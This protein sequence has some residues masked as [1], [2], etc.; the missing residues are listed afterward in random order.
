VTV[1]PDTAERSTAAGATPRVQLRRNR[2]GLLLAGGLVVVVGVLA[3]LTAGG[4]AGSLDPQAYDP[5][6]SRALATLLRDRGVRVERV[7]DLQGVQAAATDATT[8]FLGQPELLSDEELALL[9]TLPGHVVIAGAGPRTVSGL[10]RD[11]QVTGHQ[12]VKTRKPTCDVAAASNAG[13]ADVGGFTY[14]ADGSSTGC[15]GS[16]GQATLLEVPDAQLLL[17]GSTSLFT[18]DKL[19]RHGNAALAIGLL[20]QSDTLVWLVPGLDRP[21]LGT[22][23]APSPDSLL[24]DGFKS[25]K[26]GLVLAVGVLALHRGRRLGRVVPEPLPVIVPAAET[27]RGRGRLYRAA[28]SRGVAAEALRAS[29][30]DQVGVRVGAG[31]SPAP[32]VLLAL[33]GARTS[34]AATDLQDLLYGPPPSDDA[35]LVRLAD[36]LDSLIL[37]VAGS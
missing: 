34:R 24:P 2:A 3:L 12:D 15:Y 17:V 21:A 27:V 4:A 37:E 13:P 6:G 7:T 35:A 33:T 36:D 25:L 1:L 11:V 28:G 5:S 29:A 22:R 31:R 30:R 19:A 8:V 26:L 32:E 14:Q 23:P 9:S 10:Q 18:N 16:S 20:G